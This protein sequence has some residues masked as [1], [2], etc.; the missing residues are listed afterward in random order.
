LNHLFFLFQREKKII[1][2]VT[3]AFLITEENF[4]K[5]EG[6]LPLKEIPLYKYGTCKHSEEVRRAGS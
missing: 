5:R 4:F 2:N 3:S 1:E 6:D